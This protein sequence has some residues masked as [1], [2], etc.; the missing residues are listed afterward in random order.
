MGK[1][2]TLTITVSEQLKKKVK[3]FVAEHSTT[4]N[5]IASDF[6]ECY[7]DHYKEFG[8]LYQKG[9]DDEKN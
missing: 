8:K 1:K 5:K 6:L 4:I 9:G 7:L 2:E 3:V